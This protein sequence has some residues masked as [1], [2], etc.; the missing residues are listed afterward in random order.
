MHIVSG[1][2]WLALCVFEHLGLKSKELIKGIVFDSAPPMS[3][4][5]A[6]GG[7]VSH[8]TKNPSLKNLYSQP[9]RLFRMCQGINQKFEDET[10]IKMRSVFYPS[11][12]ML[13]LISKDD[14][15]LSNEYV[16]KYVE[17]LKKK[18]LNVK[19]KMWDKARHSLAIMDHPEEYTLHLEELLREANLLLSKDC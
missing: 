14:P 13:F 3:D 18:G 15:V 1:S 9:F 16:L 2:F 7:Y 6:F 4:I 10:Y 19:L 5:Y 8:V 12:P 17:D 11:Q